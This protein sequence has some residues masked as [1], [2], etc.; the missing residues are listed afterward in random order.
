MSD[1]SWTPVISNV[2]GAVAS[3]A[4]TGFATW[5]ATSASAN[6]RH[7]DEIQKLKRK[8]AEELQSKQKEFNDFLKS[9]K[10]RSYIDHAVILDGAQ[11]AG[12][13]AFVAKWLD[14]TLNI[15]KVKIAKTS[16]VADIACQLCFEN[17]EEDG[18]HLEI[19][20]RVR[21]VDVPGE[22]PEKLLNIVGKGQVKF[23][24]FVI[25]PTDLEAACK[26]LSKDHVK[27]LYTNDLL[28][29]TCLGTAVYISKK[30]LAT[31]AQLTE[32][33]DWVKSNLLVWLKPHHGDLHIQ[34]G[35]ALNGEGIFEMQSKI[36]SELNL[37]QHFPRHQSRIDT[38]R[39]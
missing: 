32:A 10:Y 2:L 38:P 12:K 13:S 25:D 33:R 31:S 21:F 22:A 14:P 18:K 3:A 34:S 39:I 23:V 30:D 35:S 5:F 8:H 1:Q 24:L 4:I 27:M 16:S 17:R 36:A 26:R 11:S 9:V 37:G 29:R 20:H 6:E 15:N 7:K 28:L 19:I